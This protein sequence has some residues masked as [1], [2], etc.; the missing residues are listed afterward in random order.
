[1]QRYRVKTGFLAPHIGVMVFGARETPL[2][3]PEAES[4]GQ[5]CPSPF[6]LRSGVPGMFLAYQR[7]ENTDSTG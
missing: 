5:F 6:I 7:H 1:V 3:P 2:V 4:G